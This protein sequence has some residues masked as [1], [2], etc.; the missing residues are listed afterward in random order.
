MNTRVLVFAR[1]PR[2]GR[3]KTRL[4]AEIGDMVATHVYAELLA[5]TL[6]VVTKAGA[7]PEVWLADSP[8]ATWAQQIGHSWSVQE[9]EDLGSRMLHAFRRS[10]K[11]GAGQVII[12][13][14]DCPTL[15]PRHIVE[16]G[17][18]LDLTQIVLGPACDGGYWLVGQRSPGVD[19]FSSIP[20]SA[21]D[22]LAKTRLRASELHIDWTELEELEDIDARENL[23][24]F[25]HS[26]SG[27]KALRTRLEIL[28]N[29]GS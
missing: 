17:E 21:T 25:V 3:V 9:G 11:S 1:E 20:W 7:Q 5:H 24:A 8:D 28:L 13:G 12:I 29:E 15:E 19:L 23:E 14:S 22:T 4:A 16:A 6:D 27:D 26:P 2:F 10:F 18:Q